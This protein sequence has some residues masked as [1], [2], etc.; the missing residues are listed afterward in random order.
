VPESGYGAAGEQV[1]VKLV[2]EDESWVEIKDATG[3]TIFAQLNAP[4]TER[5][6]RGHPPFDVVVGNA[7]AVRLSYRDRAVDLE[8]HT[9]VDVARVVLP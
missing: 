1:Y 7:H 6:V 5:V 2:F 8:P 4:G 9:R 3:E